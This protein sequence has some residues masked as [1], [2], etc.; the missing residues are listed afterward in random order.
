MGLSR[1]LLRGWRFL[2]AGLGCP[3]FCIPRVWYR[4]TGPHGMFPLTAKFW[5][6]C[7]V[8][9]YLDYTRIPTVSGKGLCRK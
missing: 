5:T 1:H 4:P 9:W 7:W 3:G 8:K 2:R 6:P